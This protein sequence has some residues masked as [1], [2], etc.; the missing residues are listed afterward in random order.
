MSP[1]AAIVIL[2]AVGVLAGVLLTIGVAWLI[3]RA[4]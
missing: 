1:D 4:R 2:I 3:G